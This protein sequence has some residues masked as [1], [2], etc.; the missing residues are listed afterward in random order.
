MPKFPEQK[1]QKSGWCKWIKP[2]MRGYL[3]KCCGCGVV[4][5]VEF[6]ALKMV[7]ENRCEDLPLRKFRV[8]FRMKNRKDLS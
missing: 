4:H 3:M 1:A 8:E 2:I 6:R 5:E 7:G